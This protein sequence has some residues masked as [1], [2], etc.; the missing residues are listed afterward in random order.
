[1]KIG[2]PIREHTTDTENGSH[3]RDDG[4]PNSPGSIGQMGPSGSNHGTTEQRGGFP[5]HFRLPGV[6]VIPLYVAGGRPSD[7]RVIADP[8]NIGATVALIAWARSS[9]LTLSVREGL[10]DI[11]MHYNRYCPVYPGV[12]FSDGFCVSLDMIARPFINCL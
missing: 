8:G 12:R 6:R 9:C 4:D 7:K 3:F 5:V 11:G 1:L 10:V 2:K